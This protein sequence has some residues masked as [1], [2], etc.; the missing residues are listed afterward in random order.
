[1]PENFIEGE[2]LRDAIIASDARAKGRIDRLGMY[3]NGHSRFLIHPYLP[4]Q[5]VKDLEVFHRCMTAKSVAKADQP[6][7]FVVDDN[8]A[9]RPNPLPMAL[10][11]R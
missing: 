6:L 3:A 2:T 5:Q 8:V 1:L 11:R 9:Q 4:Y 10:M 7:C